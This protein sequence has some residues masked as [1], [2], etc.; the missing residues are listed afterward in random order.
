MRLTNSQ[1]KQVHVSLLSA[2]SIP[3][4][5]AELVRFHLGPNLE[6]IATGN[7][8]SEIAFKL[9]QWAEENGCV[10]DLISGM[11]EEAPRNRYV[12]DLFENSRMWFETAQSTNEMHKLDFVCYGEKVAILVCDGCFW[13]NNQPN[14]SVLECISP[15]A[16]EQE[17]FAFVHPRDEQITERNRPVLYG[18]VVALKSAY[19]A[20]YVGADLDM[21]GNPL[22]ARVPW[23]RTWQKFDLLRTP[24]KQE[25]LDGRLRHGSRFILRACTG[26]FVMYDRDASKQ[27][28]S[29]VE[30]AS[31]WECFTL[32][33]GHE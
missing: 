2:F 29:V 5:L 26:K 1:A 32:H 15:S 25:Q 11:F 10:Q 3:G 7:N 24:E 16:G 30:E 22:T 8:A 28:L 4:K 17:L 14:N 9:I 18:D 23:I 33:Y 6:H 12:S 13:Q 20:Q 31:L 21:P 27:L 19:N